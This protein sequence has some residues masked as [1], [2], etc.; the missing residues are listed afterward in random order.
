M[1][2]DSFDDFSIGETVERK[3]EKKRK[4][5]PHKEKAPKEHSPMKSGFFSSFFAFFKDNLINYVLCLSFATLCTICFVFS[6]AAANSGNFA[7][8]VIIIACYLV[9]LIIA[10]VFTR[11]ITLSFY[12]SDY[13]D[14]H[15]HILVLNIILLLVAPA[16]VM[17]FILL[18]IFLINNKSA[19]LANGVLPLIFAVIFYISIC[20]ATFLQKVD[21]YLE[22]IDQKF[23]KIK[24]KK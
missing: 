7:L 9:S 13:K 8:I 19:L 3:P 10:V 20:A 5:K 15:S 23:K 1:N 21:Y 4:E 6:Q 2:Y 18:V 24:K 12:D 16:V 14:T 11:K 17:T 22:K